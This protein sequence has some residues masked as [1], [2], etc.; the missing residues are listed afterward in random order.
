MSARDLLRVGFIVLGAFLIVSALA[1][2]VESLNHRPAVM[3]SG[4]QPIPALLE[5]V[6]FLGVA[7]LVA[8]LVF[9]VL[10]GVL[11]IMRS[12][13]WSRRLVPGSS[14]SSSLSASTLLAVGLMLVGVVFGVR[15][16]AG[17][18]GGVAHLVAQMGTER[19]TYGWGLA[20]G[21]L[22]SALVDLVCGAALFGWGRRSILGAP[23]R[24]S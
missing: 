14:G 4:E 24:F 6:A 22:G 16:M 1:S 9:G 5:W 21:L 13:R 23:E 19:E 7:S 15:G 17:V 10:P 8:S 18:V 11:L 12:E 2:L 3:A 20:W